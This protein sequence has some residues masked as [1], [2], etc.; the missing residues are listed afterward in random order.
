MMDLITVVVPVY[1]AEKTIGKCVDSLLSQSY[2]NV[3]VILVNDCSNDRSLDICNEYANKHGNVR[4]L[5]NE[6]NLGVSYTRNRGIDA[7]N[8]KY[9]CF[10]DSDDYVDNDYLEILYNIYQEYNL[11]PICGF[12]FHDEY[13]GVKPVE[14]RWSGG[15]EKV[16]L[17][18]AF[19]LND[20][21]I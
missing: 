20:E 8:G 15:S 7:T 11:F 14:Y 13:S 17:G 16:S 3:E 12:I 4:V 5:S 19:R 21:Y 1:N 6:K 2:K 18:E 10:V 9:I